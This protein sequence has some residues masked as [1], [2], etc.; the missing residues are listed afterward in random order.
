MAKTNKESKSPWVIS[1]LSALIF[2]PVGSYIYD[3][4][5]NTP[6]ITPLLKC[7]SFVWNSIFNFLIPVWIIIAGTVVIYFLILYIKKVNPDVKN[8]IK[9]KQ[10]PLW[11]N[12]KKGILKR[13]TWAWDYELNYISEKYEITNLLPYCTRCDIKTLHDFSGLYRCP[14]CSDYFNLSSSS[15]FPSDIEA[16]IIDN[17]QKGKY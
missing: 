6:I 8:T 1:I 12:Y 9:E 11:I 14:K 17:I 7:F 2:T 10:I 3:H 16:L 5:K 4:T 13:W 15:E